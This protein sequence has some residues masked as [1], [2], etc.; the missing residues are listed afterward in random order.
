M[1][2]INDQALGAPRYR[3]G[4]FV[5]DIKDRQ[6]WKGD[7]RLPLNAR[8]FDALILLVR[9]PGTLIEKDR[10]F[11]EV[12]HDVVVSDSALAQCIKE[13][14]KQLG[15]DVAN[16]RY[17][18]TVPRHGY[19]FVAAVESLPALDASDVRHAPDGHDAEATAPGSMDA[20]SMGVS[21]VESGISR[22]MQTAASELGL[23]AVGGG[24]A[25]IFVG[26]LYGFGLASVDAAAGTISTLLV[27]ISLSVLA[28]AIGGFGVGVG[29]AGVGLLQR[30]RVGFFRLAP[31]L[32]AAVGGLVVGASAKL[33]GVDAFNLLF[34]RAPAGI[35]GGPEG[36]AMGAALA[37]GALVG[38]RR[39]ARRGSRV[40]VRRYATVGAGIAGAI[41][42]GLLPL[43][44]GRMM[45]GSLDL[46]ARSFSDSRLELDRFGAM[47]GEVS[48]GPATQVL[49]GVAEGFIF[50]CCVIGAMFLLR[51]PA[52]YRGAQGS[53]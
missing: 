17:I 29:L 31:V 49:L 11:A 26:L 8:Y 20:V 33:L 51:T 6:L 9:E 24:T 27:V 3:F 18:Q 12:W 7:E 15:D 30:R 10:F 32:A 37:L 53:D 43:A 39:G 22:R 34:G 16:P 50:G 13:V 4:D 48:F 42:G 21:G 36:A 2:D 45:G 25:G 28:G 5:L 47:L 23:S 38:A 44:G 40:V 14:R 46:V 52:A 1:S 19:R 35:T 41:T